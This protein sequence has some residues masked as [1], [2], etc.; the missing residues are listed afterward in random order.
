MEM[1]RTSFCL[2]RCWDSS[3]S[4]LLPRWTISLSSPMA[5][6]TK[7]PARSPHSSKPTSP[8]HRPTMR[9]PSMNPSRGPQQGLLLERTP[10]GTNQEGLNR[11][12]TPP[13]PLHRS[14]KKR[15]RVFCPTFLAKGKKINQ[16]HRG[17][18]HRGESPLRVWNLTELSRKEWNLKGWSLRGVSLQELRLPGQSSRLRSNLG[19]S[20]AINLKLEGRKTMCSGRRRQQ[21]RSLPSTNTLKSRKRLHLN[22]GNQ[23][24]PRLLHK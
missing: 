20:K 24:A 19:C 2:P 15:S 3:R 18:N 4:K 13:F 10:M 1:T 23:R 5:R 12:N 22:Q 11:T 16:N 7:S 9:P 21:L 17:L 6:T 8:S 14:T